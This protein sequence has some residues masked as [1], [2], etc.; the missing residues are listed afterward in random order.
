[1]KKLLILLFSLFFLSSPSVFADDISDFSIE[2][3]SIGDSLLDYMSEDEIFAEIEVS[4]NRYL[5]LKE[6]YKYAE[7]D[8]PKNFPMYD[9]G[10]SVLIK[11][12]STNKY[13]SNVNE[14][15]TILFIRGMSN[16]IEDFDGCLQE[17]NEVAEIVSGM[18]PNAFK[19]EA[20]SK[21][22]GDPSGNSIVD[23]I[24]FKYDSGD[25]VS[26]Y[27]DDVE[28]TLRLKKNWR[29][30]LSVSIFSAETVSWINNLK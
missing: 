17:R 12:N 4:K 29:E 16:Y 28:E 23:Y 30:G 22:R 11:N 2:G 5:H 24:F 21:Y 25:K 9:H 6:P 13:I 8:L 20:T 18:F 15:Y 7:V 3:I 14:K 26:I 10:L 19:S 27:C 1:M